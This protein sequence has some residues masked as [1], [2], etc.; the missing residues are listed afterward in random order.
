[1][2][3]YHSLFL[4]SYYENQENHSLSFQCA[5]IAKLL[6]GTGYINDL[7]TLSNLRQISRGSLRQA[8]REL[9]RINLPRTRESYIEPMAQ[10]PRQLL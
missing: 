6:T 3:R 1:M 8:L 5:F 9:R 7:T 2:F 10:G 4:L